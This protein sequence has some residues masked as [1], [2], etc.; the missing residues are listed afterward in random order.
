MYSAEDSSGD[1]AGVAISRIFDDLVRLQI[2]L[3]NAIDARLQ[4]R[5]EL[6]MGWFQVMRL[7]GRIEACRVNDIAEEL[8]ITVG[9]ASKV[10]DRVEAAGLCR[11]RSN[12]G[13]R[14]SSIIEL[15]PS[16]TSLLHTAD[17]VYAEEL[18]RR[19]QAPLPPRTLT[20]FG[21]TL[22]RLRSAGHTLE[23]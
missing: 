14:R 8:R 1:P 11:R 18:H 13:D 7:V 12:P 19:L 4:A 6:S 23:N 21:N 15:T 5:C 10:V 20:Q 22:R 2:E 16:G 17:A 3:W 9:G